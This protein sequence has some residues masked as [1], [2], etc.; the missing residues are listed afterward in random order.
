[1]HRYWAGIPLEC[2]GKP[3]RQEMFV[4]LRVVFSPFMFS[5]LMY[6]LVVITSWQKRGRGRPVPKIGYFRNWPPPPAFLWWNDNHNT[7]H[8]GNHNTIKSTKR[9]KI[10]VARSCPW[11]C[12]WPPH[13]SVAIGERP[14][15]YLKRLS[16]IPCSYLLQDICKS[17]NEYN[18]SIW[19]V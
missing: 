17:I 2:H 10:K 8:G 7:I 9:N 11:R 19:H 1:M 15:R 14:A 12:P 5:F 18:T 4:S 6:G 16:G 3:Q 13:N